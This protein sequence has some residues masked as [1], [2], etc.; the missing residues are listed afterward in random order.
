MTTPTGT[1]IPL[2][3]KGTFKPP[4]GGSPFGTVTMS[5]ATWDRYYQQPE[6]LYTLVKMSGGETAANEAALD[7]ALAAFPNAKV[8]TR[9]KFIDNQIAGL[10]SVLN[11]LYVLLALSIVVSLFGIVNTLVLSVFERTREIGMLRAVG[12]SQAPGPAHDPPR[13][14][15]HGVH[16]LDHRD[17]AR[18]RVRRAAG[19]ARQLVDRVRD[20]G[21]L[22]DHL[23]DRV[24]DRRAAGGDLPRATGGASC[25][26]SKR[27]PTS[28]RASEERVLARYPVA[29]V[30]TPAAGVSVPSATAMSWAIAPSDRDAISGSAIPSTWTS[31]RRPSPRSAP[32]QR[33][34]RVDPVGADE[35][36]VTERDQRCGASSHDP[37]I[38]FA[39][40]TVENGTQPALERRAPAPRA[41][42]PPRSARPAPPGSPRSPAAWRSARG[43]PCERR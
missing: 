2:V 17:P 36:A 21:R 3:L 16:R 35:L 28:R 23:P 15:D 1:H 4:S 41:P 19:C 13:E 27:S 9:Q 6:N 39:Q 14:R 22:A 25:S 8:Q 20:P 38:V 5:A 24:V 18:D 34:Q 42:G 40:L 10:S 12:T 37:R 26:R 29:L 43:S 32:S 11:I 31:V 7:R 30:V 33:H